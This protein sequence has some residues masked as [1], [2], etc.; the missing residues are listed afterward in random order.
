MNIHPPVG[1]IAFWDLL[2]KRK[3]YT[4]NWR[5]AGVKNCGTSFLTL[6]GKQTHSFISKRD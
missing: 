3:I 4:R 2:A 5:F 1:Q 6:S